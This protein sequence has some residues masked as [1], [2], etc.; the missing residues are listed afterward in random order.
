MK[1][2]KGRY[3]RNEKKN[4]YVSDFEAQAI[5]SFCLKFNI[6]IH[7]LMITGRNCM[8]IYSGIWNATQQQH[9]EKETRLLKHIT[10][11]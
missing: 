3:A 2:S 11:K 10:C 1:K 8:Y 9:Q 4:L 5:L 7:L 6:D